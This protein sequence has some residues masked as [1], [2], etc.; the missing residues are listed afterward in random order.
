ML[1]SYMRLRSLLILVPIHCTV[2]GKNLIFY[3]KI[4]DFENCWFLDNNF[5]LPQPISTKFSYVV[6]LYVLE[7]YWF[8]CHSIARFW[9][10]TWFFSQKSQ[11]LRIVGFRTITLVCL[12]QF[13]PNFDMLLK[14]TC[15]RSLLILM[16]IYCMVLGKNLIFYQKITDFENCKYLL[17][18]WADVY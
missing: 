11:I 12:N 9:R 2:L 18:A 7:S 16:S 17:F 13:L 8:W 6:K 5:S 4:T 14:Y 3:S 10:K 1:L 15:L